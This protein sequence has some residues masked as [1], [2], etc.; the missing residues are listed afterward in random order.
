[1]PGNVPYGKQRDFG[2]VCGGRQTGSLAAQVSRGR[3]SGDFNRIPSESEFD[4]D[5]HRADGGAETHDSC[6]AERSCR[7]A[8]SRRNA[9]AGHRRRC[10]LYVDPYEQHHAARGIDADL[11]K[12]AADRPGTGPTTPGVDNTFTVQVADSETPTPQTATTTAGQLSITVTN[13]LSG[14]YAFELSGF[15]ASGAVCRR[16]PLSRRT[17]WATTFRRCRRRRLHFQDGLH[18]IN[19]F[20]GTF[21][22]GSDNRGQL[23]F[24][25]LTGSP[26]FAFSLDSTGAHGRIVEFDA[27]GVRGLPGQIEQQNTATCASNSTLSGAGPLGAN[28]VIGVSGASG[29]FSGVTPGPMAMVGRFTAEVPASKLDDAGQY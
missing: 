1:M 21:T 8:V 9:I 2:D 7:H 17:A 6:V 13:L 10:A 26:T 23:I 11:R 29:N 22:I 14:N 12:L 19:S 28:W 27:T 15:N 16:R 18:R 3:D 4:H 25:S 20:T 24:S 5:H